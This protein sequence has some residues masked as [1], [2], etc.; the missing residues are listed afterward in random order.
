MQIFKSLLEDIAL[1]IKGNRW[2]VYIALSVGVGLV[3]LF[4]MMNGLSKLA[5][6]RGSQSTAALSG[7]A[8]TDVSASGPEVG[9]Y[10]ID[11]STKPTD[12]Q[13]RTIQAYGSAEKAI[14][15]TFGSMAWVT[16]SE[17]QVRFRGTTFSFDG[18]E[19]QTYAITAIKQGEPQALTFTD[20]T[21]TTYT[22]QTTTLSVLGQDGKTSICT[23]EKRTEAD[24]VF[25]TLI[26]SPFADGASL[27]AVVPA[28]D[29]SM[30]VP[31][32]LADQIGGDRDGLVKAMRDWASKNSPAAT[33][34]TWDSSV[35]INWRKGSVSFI[36]VL[37]DAKSTNVKVWYSQTTKQFSIED[38]AV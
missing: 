12:E 27:S 3:L 20:N 1:V 15:D 31:D 17:K 7:E 10:D 33:S 19:R 28:K 25:W 32:E 38:K 11:E 22:S 6:S 9:S 24:G 34:G 8:E 37:N 35:T 30:E 16:S 13:V 14:V 5:A 23:L 26:G 21:T 29:F 36:V 2:I 18:G 4:S